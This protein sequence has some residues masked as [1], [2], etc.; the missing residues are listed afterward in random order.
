MLGDYADAIR[1]FGRNARLYVIHVVGMDTVHGTWLV[2]FNL[3]LLT[4]GFSIEFIGLR[5]LLSGI[6]GAI[7]AV[8][9]GFVS[10]RIGRK[11]SFI[12]GDGMGAALG[13]VSILSA[14]EPILLATGVLGAVFGTLHGV[15]EPAFMAENSEP[16][17]RVHLFSVAEG[18]RTGSAMIG[19]LIA[20]FVPVLAAD[21]ADKITLYRVATLVGLAIW[22]LSLI[23][24]LMLRRTAADAERPRTV[25]LSGLLGAVRHRDRVGQLIAVGAVTSLGFAFV[26]PL[27]NVFYHEGLHAHENEIGLTFASGELFLALAALVAPFLIRRFT[28]VQAVVYTRLL[29]VPFILVIA[30]SPSLASV[31]NVL[32]LAGLAYVLRIVLSNAAGPIAD[33]FA[34]EILDPGERAT[35]VGLRS[36][37]SQALG[38]V[39]GFLGSRLMAGGDF[40]T[41]FVVMATLYAA[42]AILYWFWFRPLESEGVVQLGS[43]AATPAG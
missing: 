21:L 23:P 22:G 37:V 36:A 17:E 13:V 39:G 35:M 12:L 31:S 40:V 38:A 43:A 32:T 26:G 41:P 27:F 28:N 34:M 10:D 30:F 9:A 42:A 3:Y 1:R 5:L 8:P 20:G 19:S 29:A 16:P 18:L 6:A 24:A 15:S 14:S 7:A 4:V 2:L 33:A 25:G 11:A